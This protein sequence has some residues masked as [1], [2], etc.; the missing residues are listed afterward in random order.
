VHRDYCT[1]GVEAKGEVSVSVVQDVANISQTS[2]SKLVV[3]VSID[4]ATETA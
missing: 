1:A 2:S 4:V 3:D